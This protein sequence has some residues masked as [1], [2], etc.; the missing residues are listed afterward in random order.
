MTISAK[1]KTPAQIIVNENNLKGEPKDGDVLVIPVTDGL[2]Y[3][4]KPFDTTK[5]I[6]EKFNMTESELL[7]KN[8]IP[9]VYVGEVL[10]IQ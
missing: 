3:V 1:F 2:L 10:I 6:A 8:K 9:Y 4:V 7:E 5:S